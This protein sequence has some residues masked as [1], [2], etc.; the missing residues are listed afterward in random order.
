MHASTI[1]AKTFVGQRVLKDRSVPL[2][3]RQRSAFILFD[4]KRTLGEVLSAAAGMGVAEQ[5]VETLVDAGLLAPSGQAGT[6]NA[7]PVAA[8]TVAAA[9]PVDIGIASPRPQ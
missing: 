4:G 7:M 1:L 6:V 5:D 9:A 8:A 3:Q 2:A